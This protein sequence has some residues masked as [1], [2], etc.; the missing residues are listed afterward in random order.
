MYALI[1]SAKIYLPG[2][3]LL[4]PVAK[5]ENHSHTCYLLAKEGF[6]GLGSVD[7]APHRPCVVPSF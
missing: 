6:T 3:V 1:H 4:V 2:T 7:S 5:T